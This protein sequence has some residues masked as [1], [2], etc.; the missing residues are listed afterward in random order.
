M[1][2]FRYRAS[3]FKA[4]QLVG[5]ADPCAW[6]SSWHIEE[7]I[8]GCSQPGVLQRLASASPHVVVWEQRFSYVEY[9]STPRFVSL[10]LSADFPAYGNI[11]RAELGSCRCRVHTR[12]RFDRPHM[13]TL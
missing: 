10:R 7:N 6:P 13:W 8:E 1:M 2:C 3:S 4:D 5:S 12:S 11:L 9:T